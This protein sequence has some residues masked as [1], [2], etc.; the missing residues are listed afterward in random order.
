MSRKQ[1]LTLRSY[2][3]AEGVAKRTLG[4]CWNSD[5]VATA[6]KSGYRAAMRDL[7]KETSGLSVLRAQRMYYAVIEWLRPL[8]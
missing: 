5:D 1:K 7:R 3:Y 2:A 8:R 6:Y 4:T